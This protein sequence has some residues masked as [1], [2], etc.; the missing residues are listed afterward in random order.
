[1]TNT[2]VVEYV[3]T[4]SNMDKKMYNV[5]GLNSQ[6]EIIEVVVSDTGFDEAAILCTD[7]NAIFESANEDSFEFE[8]EYA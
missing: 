4:R 8:P 1:M 6:A 2:Q 5:L 3:M 7:K